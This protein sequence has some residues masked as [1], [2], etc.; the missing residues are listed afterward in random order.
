MLELVSTD[1][2]EVTLSPE[3]LKKLNIRYIVSTNDFDEK[4]AAGTTNIFKDS[5]I[6][7]Q[8][9]YEGTQLSIYGCVY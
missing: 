9:Y 2:V 6:E 5:G 1:Y 8:K 7:F 4:I 3:D